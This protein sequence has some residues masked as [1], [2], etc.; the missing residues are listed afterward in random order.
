MPSRKKLFLLTLGIVVSILS[1]CL[2]NWWKHPK[3]K[4]GFII[5]KGSEFVLAI[6]NHALIENLLNLQKSGTLPTDMEKIKRVIENSSISL[7]QPAV[8]FG[9][10]HRPFKGVAVSFNNFDSLKSALESIGFQSVQKDSL[11]FDKFTAKI[12]VISKQLYIYYAYTSD[13]F[14]NPLEFNS[15][16]AYLFSA[17]N[18][19]IAKGKLLITSDIADIGIQTTAKEIEFAIHQNKNK[20]QMIFKNAQI[21]GNI[22]STA[23]ISANFPSKLFLLLKSKNQVIRNIVKLGIDTTGWDFR[24][25]KIAFHWKGVSTSKTTYTSYITDEEFNR[26]EVKKVKT[27]F[28]PNLNISIPTQNNK[29]YQ[30]TKSDSSSPDFKVKNIFGYRFLIRNQPKNADFQSGSAIEVKPNRSGIIYLNA[31]KIIAALNTLSLPIPP[32]EKAKIE[33]LKTISLLNTDSNTITFTVE[34]S[35]TIMETMS[36]LF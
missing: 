3:L 12:N 4:D 10:L 16:Q 8:L 17:F 22:D 13:N 21:S 26:I 14:K 34:T 20:L 28:E 27:T 6:N 32:K 18:S 36:V 11:N 24:S 2:W 25:G 30:N 33:L 1:I 19:E 15:E 35:N 23:V 29:W 7:I 9:S 31:Q 5:P